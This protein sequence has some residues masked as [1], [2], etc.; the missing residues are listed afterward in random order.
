MRDFEDF[1]IEC[2]KKDVAKNMKALAKSIPN[3]ELNIILSN[4][5]YC[6]EPGVPFIRRWEKHLWKGKAK[7]FNPDKVE[8]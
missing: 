3:T 2:D 1:L 5:K 7:N 8:L 6:I 4:G